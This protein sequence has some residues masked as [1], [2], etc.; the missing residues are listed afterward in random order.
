MPADLVDADGQLPDIAPIVLMDGDDIGKWLQQQKL[1]GA[2][3]RLLPEQQERLSQLGVTPA[4][5][6]SPAPATK[7]ATKEASQA[8]RRSRSGWNG[9]AAG[10]CRGA[11]GEEIAVDG[12]AEPVVVKLGVL[13][14]NAKLRRDKLAQDQLGVEWA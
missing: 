13:V 1:P 4:E 2:W 10:Q 8:W 6:P 11:H 14:S 9:R 7:G 5:T 12:E 3:A